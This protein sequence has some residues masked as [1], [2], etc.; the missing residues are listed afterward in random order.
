MRSY[1]VDMESTAPVADV[2]AFYRETMERNGLTIARETKSQ[3]WAYS[4]EARSADRMHQVY[5]N[6][7]KRAQGT[8]IELM[9]HY[10]LPR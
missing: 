1:K 5:V 4:L 3:D 6:V 8:G 10:T 9:D 7:V 2:A